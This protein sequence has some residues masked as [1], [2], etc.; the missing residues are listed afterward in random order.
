ME[1]YTHRLLTRPTSD[2]TTC[3]VFTSEQFLHLVVN[4]TLVLAEWALLEIL[5]TGVLDFFPLLD[6]VIQLEEFRRKE[7]SE[8]SFR[9]WELTA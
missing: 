3:G 4:Y 9:E 7:T 8:L 5:Q 1:G 2:R 6:P